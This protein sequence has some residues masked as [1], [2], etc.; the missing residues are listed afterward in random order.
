MLVIDDDPDVH[1]ALT[2]VAEELNLRMVSQMDG[3]SGFERAEDERFSLVILDLGLPGMSGTDV[4]R[5]LRAAQPTLPI[6]ILTSRDDELSRVLGLELGADDYVTKPFSI[7][8][9]IAR[10]RAIFR[11]IEAYRASPSVPCTTYDIGDLRIDLLRREVTK[12]GKR[13][14]LSRIE[15][16]LLVFL[17]QRPGIAVT[18]EELTDGVWGYRCTGFD[19]TVTTYLSRLRQRIEDDPC[20]PRY[21]TT[22][23]GVGY[24]F[25]DPAT[26]PHEG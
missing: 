2:R 4:C 12:R 21:I 11:R 10:V 5:K 7:A 25:M 3:P 15:F 18:R 19:G 9:L 20:S 22:L 16:D 13:I 23:R 6:V 14:D 8:E 24:R 26:D 17:S 1:T